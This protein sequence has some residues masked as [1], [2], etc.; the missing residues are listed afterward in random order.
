[1]EASY[2]IK[3]LCGGGW[4]TRKA[5]SLGNNTGMSRVGDFGDRNGET[6]IYPYFGHLLD[7][8][9]TVVSKAIIDELSR[10]VVDNDIY[11]W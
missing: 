9:I 5:G 1:M 7:A 3:T 11:T 6:I 10:K 8:L 2:W 4:V